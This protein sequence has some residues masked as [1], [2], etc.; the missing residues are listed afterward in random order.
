MQV[1]SAVVPKADVAVLI[2][3]VFMANRAGDAK[4]P[5]GEVESS[6]DAREERARLD[7]LVA[8]VDKCNAAIDIADKLDNKF[9]S[10]LLAMAV[11]E[12][13]MTMRKTR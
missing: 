2:T 11:Q 12:A 10:Y 5:S 1:P 7:Q 3:E 4:G 9:L 8:L 6:H 13:R